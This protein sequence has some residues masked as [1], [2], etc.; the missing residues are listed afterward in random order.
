MTASPQRRKVPAVLEHAAPRPRNDASPRL[1]LQFLCKR[2]PQ[3]RDL[4]ERPYGR[5][6][7]LPRG[8]AALGHSAQLVLFDY[9]SGTDQTAARDGVDIESVGVRRNPVAIWRRIQDLSNNFSPDWVIGFSDIWYGILAARVARS[10]KARYAIDAYDNYESYMPWAIPAHMLWRRAIARAD[11]VT[12]AGQPLLEHMT[13]AGCREVTAVVPMAADEIFYPRNRAECRHALGLPADGLLI[14]YAGSLHA[15]RDTDL[16]LALIHDWST[17]MPS[18]RFLLSGRRLQSVKLPANAIHLGYLPDEHVPV[19]LNAMDV[20][21]SLNH[22][23]QFGQHSY[24][25][26]IYEASACGV[27]CIAASTRAT[28]WISARCDL[29]LYEPGKLDHL[30]ECLSD[31]I[32]KR[33]YARPD[34]ANWADHAR[35][36]ATRLTE[37]S[38]GGA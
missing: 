30:R 3:G 33:S 11:L 15:S 23:S 13:R 25:A 1:R 27:P 22:P 20:M 9:N 12:A 38:H 37:A 7:N 4:L 6:F 31:V 17:R 8:L 14:G 26:K 36:L 5:F 28:R 10:C 32:A 29:A 35:V 24:P 19:F 18:V 21:L 16:L 34:T 2:R